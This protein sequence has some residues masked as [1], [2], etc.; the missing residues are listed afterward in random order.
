MSFIF[1]S[2]EKRAI[3][4][5]LLR[6]CG[7]KVRMHSYQYFIRG[8]KFVCIAHAHPMWN[9]ITLYKIKWNIEES[10][11]AIEKIVKIIKTLDP[12]IRIKVND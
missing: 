2:I 6:K 3:L 8:K 5:N 9:F 12:K 11:K 7:F 4:F 1:T 10:E